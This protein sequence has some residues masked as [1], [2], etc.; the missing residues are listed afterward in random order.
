MRLHTAQIAC[1]AIVSCAVLFSGAAAV[2]DTG[3]ADQTKQ[4]E[5]PSGQVAVRP[6]KLQAT[7]APYAPLFVEQKD[8]PNVSKTYLRADSGPRLQQKQKD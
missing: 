7:F 3:S 5:L 6:R 4:I 8:T 2:A 1:F